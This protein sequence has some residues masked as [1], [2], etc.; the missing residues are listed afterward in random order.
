MGEMPYIYSRGSEKPKVSQ[1]VIASRNHGPSPSFHD[2]PG[3][4][5]AWESS[6][7]LL[8]L[9]SFKAVINCLLRAGGGGQTLASANL[10]YRSC[11]IS[12]GN[13]DIEAACSPVQLSACWGRNHYWV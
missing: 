2:P 4:S 6:A 3:C 12:D 7:G 8:R 11:L 10:S 13:E 9:S 1:Y 5:F